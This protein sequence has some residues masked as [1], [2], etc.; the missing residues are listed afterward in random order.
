MDSVKKILNMSLKRCFFL[1]LLFCFIISMAGSFFIGTGTNELQ[2]LYRKKHTNVSLS[3]NIEERII[4]FDA[5]GRY[6]YRSD[7][8]RKDETIYLIISY[9]QVLLI[10]LWVI[11]CVWLTGMLFYNRE[12]KKPLTL[13]TDASKKIA[14]NQLDFTL[15]YSKKNE[16]GILCESFEHM[17]ASLY[18]NNLEMWHS[19]EERKRINA[20]FSHDLRTPLTVIKGYSDFLCKYVPDGKITDEK[21]VSTLETMN[22]HIDRLE[23]YI[24]GMNSMQKLEDIIPCF[25]EVSSENLHK[26]LEET[27]KVLSED[28]QTCFDFSSE[29]SLINIDVDLV[30]QV[31]E[32]LLSNAVR[33]AKG[34]IKINASIIRDL[35][36]IIIE[37][38]G[39]GFSEKCIKHCTEPFFR[40][41][42]E[43]D[44]I[45]FGLGLYISRII[46]E[47]HGGRLTVSNNVNGGGKVTV[48]FLVLR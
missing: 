8:E 21:L 17:R 37:D 3:P 25:T 26:I 1:Y 41:D 36:V 15:V 20:A 32:N 42:K 4:I 47:K 18:E 7:S 16:L 13:L 10:P 31:Y 45:H 39:K 40:D 27:M 9:G 46:C 48:N 5:N 43:S 14:D 34:Y 22:N 23:R 24:Q 6:I 35:L 2:D 29:K 44:N 19:L 33:Y 28:K 38:D 12:L 30:M 11:F